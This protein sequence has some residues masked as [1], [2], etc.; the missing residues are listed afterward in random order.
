MIARL[1]RGWVA[2]ADA[3]AYASYI[4]STGIAEYTASPGNLG[5]S[6]LLRDLPDGR[7][8]VITLS[9]W[10]SIEA[11]KGFA[12]PDPEQAVFYPEDDRYLV[13][14]ETTVTHF[15]VPIHRPAARH[16]RGH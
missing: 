13:G 11:I 5:A 14:R 15:D 4:E 10:M 12:G 8:E 6:M 7:T 1:W 9:F 2:T 3:A 16:V